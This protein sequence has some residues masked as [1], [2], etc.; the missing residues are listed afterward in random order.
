M[1]PKKVLVIDG[2]ALCYAAHYTIG[3]LGSLSEHTGVIFGFFSQLHKVI[4]MTGAVHLIFCWDSRNSKR[5]RL[6]EGYKNKT[7]R[8]EP[9]PQL[10]RSFV[11][12]KLLRTKIIPRLGF[13]NSFLWS[14][15]EADDLIARVCLS[16]VND[17]KQH[18]YIVSN[19]HDL[20]QLLR[21]NISMYKISG[22]KKYTIYDFKREFG[23]APEQWPM[24]KALAGC[25][26]DT[27]P[28]IVRVG[29]KTACKYLI[30]Y[31][32]KKKHPKIDTIENIQL[33]KRNLPLVKLPF[34]GTPKLKV[35]WDIVPSY[36]E[37]L[38]FCDEMQFLSFSKDPDVWEHLFTSTP[39]FE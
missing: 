2:S 37:W 1:Q 39:L 3:T 20:Y 17:P 4:R 34:K 18:Y 32:N 9:D 36:S 33:V 27:V 8:P 6:F 30:E 15:L 5:K 10:L 21:P 23:I 14:G 35:D 7:K 26:S 24:V 25:S 11:Q 12:F 28:G 31:R 16:I 22:H 38:A 13:V 19:D 29:E